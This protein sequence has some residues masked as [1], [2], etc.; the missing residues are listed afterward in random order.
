MLAALVFTTEVAAEEYRVTL[1]DAEVAAVTWAR[2]RHNRTLPGR[3]APAPA[4]VETNEAFVGLLVRDHVA[5]LARDKRA[6]DLK[7]A[8]TAAEQGDTEK[9][10]ALSADIAKGAAARA[11]AAKPVE[12]RP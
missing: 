3:T 10:N 5:A 12:S 1:T 11:K 4:E 2:E 9:L 7:A 6:V 8:I